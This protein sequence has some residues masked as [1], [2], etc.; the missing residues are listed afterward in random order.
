MALKVREYSPQEFLESRD[1]WNSAVQESLD[2]NVF[3]TWE[4]LSAW[5]KHFG[6]KRD[7]L[8]VTLS[9]NRRIV[10]AAPLMTSVYAI[11]GFRIRKIELIGTPASD[12]QSLLLTKRRPEYVRTLV[13]HAQRRVRHWD[14]VELSDIPEG[15]ETSQMLAAALPEPMGFEREVIEVC[16]HVPLPRDFEGYLRTLNPH[17]LREIRR[18]ERR[19]KEDFDVDFEVVEGSEGVED[20]MQSIVMLHQERGLAKGHSGI[21]SDQSVLGF[22]LDVAR[23]FAENGWLLVAFLK[24]NGRRVAGLYNFRYANRVYCYLSGFDPG[25]SKYGLGSIIDLNL[26]EHCVKAGL[27]EYDFTRGEEPYKNQW[28]TQT[29]NNLRFTKTRKGLFPRLVK[30]VTRNDLLFGKLARFARVA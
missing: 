16:P 14:F 22:H 6:E 15:W 9:D 20:A 24:A 7:F 10:A 19:L 2:N 26:I 23:S 21:F 27:K 28:N 8:L 3:L 17:F 11:F 1:A 29:R 12:Y 4:W 5:W 18:R 30:W 13:E 25:Y